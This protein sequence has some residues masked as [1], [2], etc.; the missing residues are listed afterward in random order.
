M[1]GAALTG[2]EKV[3]EFD[4][5]QLAAGGKIGLVQDDRATVLLSAEKPPVTIFTLIDLSLA[6]GHMSASACGNNRPRP[7]F[8]PQALAPPLGDLF[9]P[10][11][12]GSARQQ[13]RTHQR[14]AS[15][16]A[17]RPEELPSLDV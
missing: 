2:A 3:A 7:E 8:V 13:H 6:I 14:A 17:G 1:L 10:R 16:R 11:A 15:L 4:R 12:G 9:F 5:G